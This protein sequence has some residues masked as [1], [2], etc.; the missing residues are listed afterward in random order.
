MTSGVDE[1]AHAFPVDEWPFADPTNVA[2]FTT[3]L[4]L[5][6][7]LPILL[8]THDLDDG[9]WQVLCGTTNDSADL[10]IVCLGCL[11]QRDRSIGLLADLPLGWRAWRDSVDSPWEREP[12]PP[13]DDDETERPED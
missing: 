6:R 4:V 5:D 1:H 13:P 11:Y 2:A 9:A 8:V 7:G 12:R 10:C 3:R